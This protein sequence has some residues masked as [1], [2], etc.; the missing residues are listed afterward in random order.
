[1]RN[2]EPPA[3]AVQ[4][5]PATDVQAPVGNAHTI[6]HQAF[7]VKRPVAELSEFLIQ[8]RAGTLELIE[9][10]DGQPVRDR[11]IRAELD[12]ASLA[13]WANTD[14][15]L[16]TL[17]IGPLL[18]SLQVSNRPANLIPPWVKDKSSVLQIYAD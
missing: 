15:D 14:L 17:P 11:R 18:N 4:A 5:V 2:F 9:N 13:R 16:A 1:M 3:P 8:V 12:Q 10:R 7:P 6:V